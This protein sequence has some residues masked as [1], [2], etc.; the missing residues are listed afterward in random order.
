VTSSRESIGVQW[1][2]RSASSGSGFSYGRSVPEIQKNHLENNMNAWSDG[3]LGPSRRIKLIDGYDQMISEQCRLGKDLY[4]ATFLFNKLPGGIKTKMKIMNSG[5]TR[6][7]SQLMGQIVRKY[8]SPAWRHLRPVLIEVPDFPVIKNK[9][10]TTKLHQVNGG[11][12]CHALLLVPPKNPLPL[13]QDQD[14]SLPKQSKIHVDLSEHFRAEQ[15]RYCNE[16]LYRIDVRRALHG[17]MTDY[18]FKSFKWGSVPYEDT[19]ILT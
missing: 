18:T 9:K 5:I 16:R 8:E 6:V 4:F 3:Y 15:D 2:E 14:A 17:T 11:L 10:V 19:L 12:H 1:L 7:H 13:G